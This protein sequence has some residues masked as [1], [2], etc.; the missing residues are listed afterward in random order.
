MPNMTQVRYL[1]S[2]RWILSD[3][4]KFAKQLLWSL[5]PGCD[6]NEQR[7]A[8]MIVNP[9]WLLE[10]DGGSDSDVELETT[11]QYL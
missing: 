3:L 7:D 9:D 5:R 6:A 2:L 8:E 10:G 4:E 1:K 11:S